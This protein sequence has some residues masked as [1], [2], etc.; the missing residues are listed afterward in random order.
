M[1]IKNII[2]TYQ[3][4]DTFVFQVVV[5]CLR[6]KLN[7]NT[8]SIFLCLLKLVFLL[9]Y[10]YSYIVPVRKKCK[11]SLFSAYIMKHGSWCES[12]RPWINVVKKRSMLPQTPHKLSD[13]R[14]PEKKIPT[15]NSLLYQKKSLSVSLADVLFYLTI[16]SW[17]DLQFKVRSKLPQIQ[18]NFDRLYT[19]LSLFPTNLII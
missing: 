3:L 7:R 11:L 13:Q 17:R 8:T 4:N 9:I 1:N 19:V 12:F 14:S 18:G 16:T 5:I 6:F 15:K 2:V 10:K